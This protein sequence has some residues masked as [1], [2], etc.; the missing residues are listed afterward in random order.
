MYRS[1][2]AVL[3]LIFAATAL[4]GQTEKATVRGTV[5]D[6]TGAVVPEAIITVSE[7]GTNLDR[8]TTSDT[9]GNFEVPNLQPGT[10]RVRRVYRPSAGSEPAANGKWTDIAV[11]VVVTAGRETKA[12]PLRHGP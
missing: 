4:L 8:K 10:Y 11:T 2:R 1:L 6:S 9:N 5:T 7:I 3:P 12:A